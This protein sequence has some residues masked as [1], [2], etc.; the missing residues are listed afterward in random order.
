LPSEGGLSHYVAPLGVGRF[1]VQPVEQVS[2]RVA[3][4]AA[5]PLR[6]IYSPSHDVAIDRID[7]RHAVVGYESADAANPT[8][9]ELYYSATPDP[10]GA[11]VVSYVD[12]ATGEGTF[13]LLAAPGVDAAGA[14]M[15]KDVILVLD[16]SG[17]MKGE[18]LAQAKKALDAV[19]ADLA[20]DDR[21]AAIEFSTGA[22]EFASGLQPADRAAAAR[23]WVD[24][25]HAEGGTDIDL[26]LQTAL[27]MV[28]SERPTML[29]FLTDG[30][31]TEGV[32]DAGAILRDVAS[33]APQ[34]VRFF[35]FGVGDDVDTLLLDRLTAAHHGRTTY[36]RPGQAID[37]QVSGLYAGISAPVLSD[38]RLAVNGVTVSDLYPRPLPD[39][40]A[41]SQLVLLGRYDGG[42]AATLTL[43]GTVDGQDRVYRFD[44]QSF[45][46]S[47]G[48]SFLPRLWATRKVGYLLDQI[49]L[50]GESN[51]LVDEIVDLSVRYGIVTPYTSYLV[52]EPDVLTD[53]GRDAAIE[54]AQAQAA[55]PTVVSGAGAVDKAQASATLR[56]AN[57]AAPLPA[58][59]AGADGAPV[60][61]EDVVRAAGDRT[62]VL[63]DDV[64]T[65]T[66]FD[67]EKM[68]PRQVAFGSEDYFAL[69][70]DHP[71]L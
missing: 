52:T 60:A 49:R 41:G 4:D 34:S 32:T 8:D 30:L 55:A 62:F 69:L 65:D 19:L 20:P 64:W 27:S 35:A 6:A 68:T 15:A 14:A 42:G 58:T 71:E 16:T 9:F 31:P 57:V 37:E 12:P 54:Q 63:R 11:S 70:N 38:V 23:A 67:P 2:V 39:L 59:V 44:G 13:M 3:I 5:T 51:E 1:S 47:G 45:A 43:S 18:K 61:V 36:V 48:E 21:F 26:A 66:T 33:V 10:I 25:L 46:T 24:G 22:R 29:L 40:F 50:N 17:S 56:E 28:D 7:D 53:A